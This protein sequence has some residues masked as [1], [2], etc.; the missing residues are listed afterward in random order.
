MNLESV[1]CTYISR[2]AGHKNTKLLVRTNACLNVQPVMR[3][4]EATGWHVPTH[5][6]PMKKAALLPLF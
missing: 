4:V 3:P 2:P 6:Q 5:V 1:V